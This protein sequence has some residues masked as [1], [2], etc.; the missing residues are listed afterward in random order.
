MRAF[1]LVR[2]TSR[3]LRAA[4]WKGYAEGFLGGNADERWPAAILVA[5][6]ANG[7]IVGLFS[8]HIRP[9]LRAGR[10]M[11]VGNLIAVAPFGREII[12]DRLLDSIAELAHRYAVRETEISLAQSSAWWAGLFHKRGYAL[13]DR[14]HLVWLSD[15]AIVS[16]Q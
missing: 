2:E 8:Y 10:V 3:S 9:C 4:D 16:A 5:E 6:Q 14:R 12:A 1:P 13:D 15:T 7:C 11:A